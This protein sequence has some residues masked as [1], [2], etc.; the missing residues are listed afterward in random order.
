MTAVALDLMKERPGPYPHSFTIY[1][2]FGQCCESII[3]ENRLLL[4]LLDG[5]LITR[6][7]APDLGEKFRQ[8]RE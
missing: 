4:Q 6:A 7:V 3:L 2:I 8:E 1:A 5:I